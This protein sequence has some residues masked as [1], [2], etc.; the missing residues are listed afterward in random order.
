VHEGGGPGGSD[1]AIPAQILIDRDGNLV[2][3]FI[4]KRIQD[5]LHPDEVLAAVRRMAGAQQ[6][7]TGGL[8]AS[9]E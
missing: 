1:I 3:R 2:W 4:S 5:R 6:G 8:P 7:A 9:A